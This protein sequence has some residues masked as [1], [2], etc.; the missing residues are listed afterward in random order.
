[1][2]AP[3]S[4]SPPPVGPVSKPR[5]PSEPTICDHRSYQSGPADFGVDSNLVR[6][7]RFN[8]RDF[9]DHGGELFGIH[10]ENFRMADQAGKPIAV[11]ELLAEGR[12]ERT[13]HQGSAIAQI[14]ID[15]P[16]WRSAAD[17]HADPAEFAKFY[18]AFKMDGAPDVTV[19][20][21][22]REYWLLVN[23]SDECHNFHIHQTKFV[24]LDADFSAGGRP[25]LAQCLGDRGLAPQINRN[26]LHDN[27]P[28]PPRSRVR[29]GTRRGQRGAPSTMPTVA[30]MPL[31][32]VRE[33]C[34]VFGES[35]VGAWLRV[36]FFNAVAA[37]ELL[38][39]ARETLANQRNHHAQIEGFVQEG[40]RP[41]ID[42]SQARA[43]FATA[44]VQFINAGN[45]YQR[46]KVLLNQ[47][48]GLEGPTDYD[49]ANEALP[50][51][52]GEDGALDP[53]LQIA[54]A[55]RPE[56][57]SATEQVKAQQLLI[58]SARGAYGP[59]I[60]VGGSIA[61][62]TAP[63]S[64]YVGWNAAAG[65]TLTWN[66]FQGGSPKGSSTKPKGTST[67]QPLSS[68]CCASRCAWTWIR[69]S[70]RSGPRR[71]RSPRPGMRW[72]PRAS[73][74]RWPRGVTRTVPAA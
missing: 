59:S 42:L 53:L 15:D 62:T 8:N 61:Q 18:P 24:V 32:R 66:L 67:S 3:P 10:A 23:D 55:E 51:Q 41:P 58:E 48:M 71:R 39:V 69:R 47:A 31:S 11:A 4:S 68:T 70:S 45:G 36:A 13:E 60:V 12:V 54:F 5:P 1:M 34:R 43:D 74:C 63:G 73:A 50:S 37:K 2:P 35:F 57:A 21:G 52:P 29:L 40:T 49:V 14:S 20:H 30:I 38:A 6:L 72:L 44:E 9:G 33:P 16:C 17:E 27:Y 65:V 7:I 26:V 64:N 19:A 56:I 25:S 22:A 46:S 28:L